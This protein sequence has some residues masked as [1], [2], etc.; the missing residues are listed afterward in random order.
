MSSQTIKLVTTCT[1]VWDSSDVF[2]VGLL[3]IGP[4]MTIIELF[5]PFL[6]YEKG[7]I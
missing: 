1:L 6:L 7:V 5:G 2:E 4:N 3:V